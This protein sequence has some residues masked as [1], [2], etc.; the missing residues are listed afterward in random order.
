MSEAITAN[1]PMVRSYQ[2]QQRCPDGYFEVAQAVFVATSFASSVLQTVSSPLY[3]LEMIGAAN[4]S[5]AVTP[6]I[7]NHNLE[8]Q[9]CNGIS[10][11]APHL[12]TPITVEHD[13]MGMG[14]SEEND[15]LARE[16]E[17]IA[18]RVARFKAT[19]EK[20]K[21][22]REQYFVTTLKNARLDERSRRALVR[23]PLWP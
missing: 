17:E 6:L 7:H 4:R 13:S 11:F 2:I 10:A 15:R 5:R 3:R 12:Q 1:N 18:A 9:S 21:R 8:P 23:S 16:R 20:F 19:Q 22:E 14:M